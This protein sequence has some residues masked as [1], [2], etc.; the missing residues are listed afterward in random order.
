MGHAAAVAQPRHTLAV[1]Q[2][3]IDTGHL[4]RDVGTHPHQTAGQLV[5]QLERLELQILASTGQQRLE[6]FEQ[7]RRD[8]LVAVQTEII[9]QSAAQIFQLR[10]LGG[11][12]VLDIFG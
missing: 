1:E 4:R 9:E 12:S 7:R 6:V 5:D 3:R 11:Q 2:V 10:R 8:Q